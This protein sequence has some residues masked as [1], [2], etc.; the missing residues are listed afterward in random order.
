MESKNEAI[1]VRKEKRISEIIQIRF[2]YKYHCHILKSFE[3][4]FL[5]GKGSTQSGQ[6][7]APWL[8][9]VCL[10]G[11]HEFIYRTHLYL[12]NVVRLLAI[13]FKHTYLK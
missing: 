5:V 12:E 6:Q 2:I 1:L 8:E 11:F 10:C 13:V 3:E 4:K 7:D 9:C